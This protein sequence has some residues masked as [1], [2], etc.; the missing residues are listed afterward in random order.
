MIVRES[1]SRG[2][3]FVV[4]LVG[5]IFAV[6][7]SGCATSGSK[8][9]APSRDEPALATSSRLVPVAIRHVVH[10]TPF[11]ITPLGDPGYGTIEWIVYED[12]TIEEW[13]DPDGPEPPYRAG[14]GKLPKRL[15]TEAFGNRDSWTV[16]SPE[17]AHAFA[18]ARSFVI[19]NDERGPI[20][21]PPEAEA[22]VRELVALLMIGDFETTAELAREWNARL[23]AI[24]AERGRGALIDVCR[25]GIR[26]EDE[27][28]A[29]L[30]ARR[31][32]WDELDGQES[33]R[34]VM[35][36]FDGLASIENDAFEELRSM[37]GSRE[38][39]AYYRYFPKP[40]LGGIAQTAVGELHR[41]TRVAQLDALDSL[42]QRN[43]GEVSD[44]AGSNTHLILEHVADRELLLRDVESVFRYRGESPVPKTSRALF[45]ASLETYWLTDEEEGSQSSGYG[46][47]DVRLFD[48]WRF[49]REDV[50]I[51]LRVAERFARDSEHDLLGRA[52]RAMRHLDDPDTER[53]LRS[54]VD[55]SILPEGNIQEGRD[56][57]PSG[58]GVAGQHARAA[59]AMRGD[60]ASARGLEQDARACLDAIVAQAA[61]NITLDESYDDDACDDRSIRE[62]PFALWIEHDPIHALATFGDLLLD[63]RGVCLRAHD[64]TTS[65][66]LTCEPEADPTRCRA[67][68][69]REAAFSFIDDCVYQR[70]YFRLDWP[71]EAFRTF[72]ARAASSD[73][74]A[75]TLLHIAGSMP[76]CDTRRLVGAA[77]RRLAAV[78]SGERDSRDFELWLDGHGSSSPVTRSE[79]FALL[80]A[81]DVERLRGILRDFATREDDRL[82]TF[83]NLGLLRLG[84][85]TSGARLLRWLESVDFDSSTI[86]SRI[87]PHSQESM[88]WNGGFPAWVGDEAE[89][90][91]VLLARSPCP[92]VEAYLESAARE[93]LELTDPRSSAAEPI[94]EDEARELN[95][96]WGASV[97]LL[98]LGGVPES[99]AHNRL[100]AGYDMEWSTWRQRLHDRTRRALEGSGM[101]L[102]VDSIE[103]ELT[104]GDEYDFGEEFYA[105]EGVD[106]PRMRELLHRLRADRE[107]GEYVV[108][109]ALLAVLGEPIAR[110][111]IRA[112]LDAGRYRWILGTFASSPLSFLVDDISEMIPFWIEE[113]QGTCCTANIAEHLFESDLGLELIGTIH[114]EYGETPYEQMKR[115][116]AAHE[117]AKF[118]RCRFADGKFI[119][120]IP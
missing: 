102:L 2:A 59:L 103:R 16:D 55:D 21:V 19:R 111:E 40:P 7:A 43:Q 9:A 63:E 86:L 38:L 48:Q 54:I 4:L 52:A 25:A 51:L 75:M 85:P 71:A 53:A 20:P 42:W 11:A 120:L 113:L 56:W 1:N 58:L 32:K 39:E 92:E 83:G 81:Y 23:D 64:G 34:V 41:Q 3:R 18:A 90:L 44:A 69:V 61:W 57:S 114:G 112:A 33:A 118:V 93:L 66:H 12:R 5:V 88:E 115:W 87:A 22:E 89:N 29:T 79:A 76:S 107:L 60:R 101:D 73:V 68:A 35:L 62:L 31:L 28:I 78:A 84:D 97:G 94:G 109:T 117:G 96:L 49:T 65:E 80:E 37:L 77:A 98:V 6:F 30:C 24:E 100:A 72:E 104:N 36:S 105:I 47:Q 50:P 13:H 14:E 15:I 106:H 27:R 70:S 95:R 108:A 10:D 45:H 116:W 74:A 82:A 110:R 99:T 119:G 67:C 26:L 8:R 91:C 46:H 17:R